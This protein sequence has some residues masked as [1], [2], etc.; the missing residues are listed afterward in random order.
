M[1][2]L[3]FPGPKLKPTCRVASLNRYC[4]SW[5]R[6]WFLIPPCDPVVRK[7]RLFN[8]AYRGA[9]R[10]V[11]NHITAYRGVGR[12][13][14]YYSILPIVECPDRCLYYCCSGSVL[15]PL[16]WINSDSVL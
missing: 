8:S 12:W 15:E 10:W 13:V 11:Y 5:K 4:L 2:F 9:S 1:S 14:S 3:S 16:A 7:W 6:D